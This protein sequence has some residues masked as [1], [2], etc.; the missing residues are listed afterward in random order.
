[1]KVINDIIGTLKNDGAVR[2]VRACAFWTAVVS[3]NCGLASTL[4]EEG[5]HQGKSPVPK[6]GSLTT[7]TARE[8]A[9]YAASVSLLEASI[10]VAAINSLIDI[11]LDRCVEKNAFEILKEKGEGKKVAIVGHFPFIPKLKEIASE[12]WVIEK[13]PIEGDLPEDRAAETLAQADVVGITGTSLI[14]HTFEELL[15]HCRDRFVVVL[16]PSTPLSAVL[17]DYGVDVVSG[18]R[19]IDTESVLRSISEGA[20]FRQVKGVELLTMTR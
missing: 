10:G 13:R 14:N 5:P 6:A 16:G 8:L 15:K 2:E 20:N 7:R 11:D 1:M 9:G 4:R 17:F 3:E 18:T 19:V 12:L